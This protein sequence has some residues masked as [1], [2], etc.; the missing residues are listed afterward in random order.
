MNKKKA[1]DKR[2]LK[3]GRE[4]LRALEQAKLG[5]VNGGATV[6]CTNGCTC[7]SRLTCS[8]RLC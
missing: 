5:D 6:L 7:N 1:A 8:T 2:K 3:L 4:T